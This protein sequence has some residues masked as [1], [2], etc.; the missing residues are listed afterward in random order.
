MTKRPNL[1]VIFRNEGTAKKP[2][3]VA[4]FPTEPGTNDW[5]TFT[6]YAHMGQ[7]ATGT[8]EW[9]RSTKAA[10]LGDFVDLYAELR[11][12]YDREG[13]PDAVKL[14]LTYR[15]TQAHDEARR[16]ALRAA[17]RPA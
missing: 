1:P 14:V 10:A 3:I 8:K 6:V 7:H 9:Y 12:I 15:F 13:D 11:G 16:A 2:L 5:G 4:V 17:G